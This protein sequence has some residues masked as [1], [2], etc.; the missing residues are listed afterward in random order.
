MAF[1][2]NFMQPQ[3]I[4]TKLKGMDAV[5]D[6]IQAPYT[7]PYE[8]ASYMDAYEADQNAQA[9]AAQQAMDQKNQRIASLEAQ[10]A[11]LEKS[12][13]EKTAQLQNWSGA[14]SE[15]AAIEASKIN[16]A[17]PT[18]IWR[19]NRDREDAA[20]QSQLNREA[21]ERAN[22][23][24]N[25]E[26]IAKFKNT[27]DM[28]VNTRP[29]T[30]TEGIE[31]QI[32]NLSAAIRDGKNIGADTS[33]LEQKK[34]ELEK[35]IYPEEK[36]VGDTGEFTGGTDKENLQASFTDFLNTKHSSKELKKYK[37]EH[38]LTDDQKIKI[39]QAIA[40]AEKREKNAANEK[41]FWEFAESTTKMSKAALQA[42][43]DFVNTLRESFKRMNGGV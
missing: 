9:Q 20:I 26:A 41:A 19:W 40:A 11:S 30:S 35:I 17:D 4:E 34:L 32:N 7:N 18:M 21:S 23:A 28:L 25:Y 38:G 10:I 2:W 31:Q 43:P 22:G 15:I 33:A 42:D 29:S 3:K 27:S 12:I 6:S 16:V 1:E 36:N 8:R 14:D 24:V 13:A 5:Q 39:N 37:S